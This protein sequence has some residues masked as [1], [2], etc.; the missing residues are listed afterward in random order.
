METNFG[1]FSYGGDQAQFSTPPV[2]DQDGNVFTVGMNTNVADLEIPVHAIK[3]ADLGNDYEVLI[4]K[5]FNKATENRN[6]T[7]SVAI[8]EDDNV[9]SAG[10]VWYTAPDSSHRF[11]YA[12]KMNSEL[13]SLWYR[14]YTYD[15][16]S[17]NFHI[18]R[19]INIAEDGGLVLTG[20]AEEGSDGP[21]PHL[22][23]V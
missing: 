21:F 14:Y 2:F 11:G 13:D 18:I 22:D 19:S 16:S 15:P 9:Y 4:D 17:S 23:H 10:F 20:Y 7:L 1:V 12:M 5:E 8:D 3:L 6:T